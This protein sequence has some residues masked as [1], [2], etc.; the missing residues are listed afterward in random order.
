MIDKVKSFTALFDLF[1]NNKKAA[2]A[3]GAFLL[4][5]ALLLFSSQKGTKQQESP[6]VPSGQETAEAYTERYAAELNARLSEIISHIRGAGKTEVFVTLESGAR[7]V[8]AQSSSRRTDSEYGS[9]VSESESSDTEL[10]VIDSKD[11]EQPIIL[12]RCEPVVQGVVVVCEGAGDIS[13]RTAVV[14][15]VTTAC[16]IGANRVSVLEMS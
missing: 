1:K 11:G 7:Y 3:A 10:A 8:Y 13:V 4:G 2:L 16:G 14:E 5:L 9:R 6:D 12:Y 15:A